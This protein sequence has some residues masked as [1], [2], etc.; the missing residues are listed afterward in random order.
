MMSLFGNTSSRSGIDWLLLLAPTALIL[1]LLL[2]LLKAGCHPADDS[3]MVA[4]SS[5]AI[6]SGDGRNL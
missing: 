4:A 2:A 3:V 6:H 1:L 5:P